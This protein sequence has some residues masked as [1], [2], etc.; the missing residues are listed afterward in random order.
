MAHKSLLLDFFDL[1]AGR[2][3]S[4][5]SIEE[6]TKTLELI[7]DIKNSAFQGIKQ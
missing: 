1:V 5:T 6:A 4:S 7:E 2:Q 3:N